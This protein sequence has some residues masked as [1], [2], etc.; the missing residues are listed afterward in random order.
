MINNFINVVVI[1]GCFYLFDLVWRG[2]QLYN[3]LISKKSINNIGTKFIMI[4]I[5][6]VM[7]VISMTE[8]RITSGIFASYTIKLIIQGICLVILYIMTSFIFMDKFIKTKKTSN[9]E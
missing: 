5:S 4:I 3:R 6:I 8:A 2:S 1:A 7:I 9:A